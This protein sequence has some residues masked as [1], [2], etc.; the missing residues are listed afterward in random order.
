M[1]RS[2]NPAKRAQQKAAKPKREPYNRSRYLRSIGLEPREH[3]EPK[4]CPACRQVTFPVMLND[5]Q[6]TIAMV[7]S[8]GGLECP[9]VAA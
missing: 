6:R 9:A 7:D 3:R 4:R 1:G 8:H 2:G 5:E